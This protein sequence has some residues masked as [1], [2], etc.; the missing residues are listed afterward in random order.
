MIALKGFACLFLAL[1]ALAHADD[2]GSTRHGEF[3]DFAAFPSTV[4]GNVRKIT[5]MLPPSYS[6]SSER[7]Y[8]VLYA[9]DMQNLFDEKGS[10]IG[11]EWRLDETLAQMWAAHRIPEIIVVGI[12]NTPQRMSEYMPGPS[13]DTYIKFIATELKPFIDNRFRTKRGPADTALMGSSMGALISVWGALTKPNVFGGAA[14]LSPSLQFVA[15]IR[16]RM[17]SD[18][19]ARIHWYMDIGT[20]EVP[21][22]A[23]ARFV[24]AF[25]D[26]RLALMQAGYREG[27]DFVAEVIP[28]GQHN[29]ASW[30]ARVDKP[31]EFLFGEHT[32]A[33]VTHR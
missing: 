9:H 32:E 12:A 23:G 7:R 11:K 13:G 26:A 27:T 6:I 22:E 2:R 21:G 14:G 4:L 10:F 1:T 30:A 19:P 20:D 18:R 25:R 29:E 31:L 28:G 24:Q 8:P 16:T 17:E 5:V 3:K 33:P 15:E